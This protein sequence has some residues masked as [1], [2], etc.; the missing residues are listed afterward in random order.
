MTLLETAEFRRDPFPFY[1]VLR[2]EQPLSFGVV[3][4]GWMLTRYVDV[5]SV[6]SD[7]RFSSRRVPEDA[8]LPTGLEHLHSMMREG[9]RFRALWVLHSDAPQHT[10]LR[11]LV[12]KAF[13]PR[14]VEASR[15]KIREIV[16][17]LLEPLSDRPQFDVIA[18]FATPLPA[19]VLCELLRL[20][21]IDWRELRRLTDEIVAPAP[22]I[23]S[24]A[25]RQIE[26]THIA[27]QELKHWV[28][29]IL[30]ARRQSPGPDILSALI[31][32]SENED[33][34][35]AQELTAMTVL[36]L[37]AGNEPTTHLVGNALV[38]LL[39]HRATDA[40]RAAGA[41]QTAIEELLRYES[42][43]QFLTRR[44]TADI[45][46][47]ARRI[48]AGSIV[49]LALNSA[50]R[51]P[52]VFRHADQLDLSRTDAHRHLSFGHG[53]HH[54]IGAALARVIAEVA[55][56]ALV[57]LPPLELAID[58]P[59]WRPGTSVRGLDALPVRFVRRSATGASR[60]IDHPEV[61]DRRGPNLARRS[62]EGRFRCP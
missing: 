36:L 49:A 38:T 32:A 54:C 13:T 31:T 8:P 5:A 37:T 55:L 29:G 33:R 50:N 61:L 45:E 2:R 11:R 9:R 35:T 47:H 25:A 24:D 28:E 40:F 44:A 20:P 15:P 3:L 23:G 53:A 42:P 56:S 26:R 59:T 52:E 19:L 43:S 27:Q 1:D 7:K 12:T 39:T 10:R 51:D 21:T 6:L 16:R 62:H 58:V 34:L 48:P 22:Y 17:A 41:R 14:A 4:P 18:D 57:E 30:K 60:K 46:M